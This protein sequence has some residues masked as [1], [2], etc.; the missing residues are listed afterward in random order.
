MRSSSRTGRS[1]DSSLHGLVVVPAR[2]VTDMVLARPGAAWVDKDDGADP[3]H[4]TLRHTQIRT[5]RLSQPGTSLPM[6]AVHQFA[7]SKLI[8]PYDDV[9]GLPRT[10]ALLRHEHLQAP[11]APDLLR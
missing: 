2:V 9:I 4:F 8:E 6:I 10:Y 7:T 3:R 1:H 11:S 5:T